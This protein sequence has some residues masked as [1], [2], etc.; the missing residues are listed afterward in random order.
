MVKRLESQI[1]YEWWPVFIWDFWK[2]H[3]QYIYHCQADYYL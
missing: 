1:T 2:D 3:H